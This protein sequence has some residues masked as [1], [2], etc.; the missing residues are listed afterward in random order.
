MPKGRARPPFLPATSLS[1][2][3]EP[4][5]D[6]PRY[7]KRCD[8]IAGSGGA[9][10][11][12]A[13]ALSPVQALHRA[14]NDSV[15]AGNYLENTART[16]CRTELDNDVP[17]SPP[18]RLL[19]HKSSYQRPALWQER[20]RIETAH[21]LLAQ[22]QVSLGVPASASWSRVHVRNQQKLKALMTNLI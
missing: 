12:S 16:A 20:L 9:G 7:P 14:C 10:N 5:R 2:S 11:G 8:G 6:D 19:V 17:V 21:A 3:L 15:N 13:V 1:R 22:W 18:G 4:L